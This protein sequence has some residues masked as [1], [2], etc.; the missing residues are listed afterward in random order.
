MKSTKISSVIFI[1]LL[2]SCA[3]YKNDFKESSYK[4]LSL[5]RIEKEYQSNN[6]YSVWIVADYIDTRLDT[7]DYY[8]N[9]R[10]LNKGVTNLYFKDSI[11]IV[12]DFKKTNHG[13]S[14]YRILKTNHD[15]LVEDYTAKD[16]IELYQICSKLG[17]REPIKMNPIQSLYQ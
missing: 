11:L 10:R 1:S 17:I 6:K 14:I 2:A 5:F 16:S 13:Y 12:A 15:K 8:P 9:W 4:D 3:I 7:V